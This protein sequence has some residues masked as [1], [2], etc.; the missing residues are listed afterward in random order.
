MAREQTESLQIRG[1]SCGHCVR[2]VEDALAELDGVAVDQVEIGAA[3]VRYDPDRT[4]PAALREAVEDAG[5]EV[6]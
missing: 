3:T 2:A 5:F 1:M 6:A 4:S